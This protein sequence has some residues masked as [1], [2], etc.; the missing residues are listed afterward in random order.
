[1]TITDLPDIVYHGTISIH[2]DSL[3]SGIDINKGYFSADFG[4]GFYTT[5]NYEQ[6]KNIA[7][8]RAE[9][10]LI[11][12]HLIAFPMIMS[13]SLDLKALEKHKGKIFDET[14]ISKWKEFVY[15][16][17][18]GVKASISNFHNLTKK[19]HYVYGYVADSHIIDMTREARKGIITFGD[20]SDS[21]K[22]LKNGE[23]SQLSFH[24]NE[25]IKALRVV[26]IELIEREEL[27]V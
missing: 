11:R 12:K 21:L 9:G 27:L 18:V 26:N 2:K 16:N 17:R 24:S 25:I 14:E 19:Y 8:G 7:I 4:Q 10:Y 1:M 5:G 6:A 20:F 15:N 13:Y 23:Y 3:M 22:I